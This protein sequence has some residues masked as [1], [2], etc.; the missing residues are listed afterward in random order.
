MGGAVTALVRRYTNRLRY[1]RLLLLTAVLFAVDLAV[2]DVLP[3]ADEILLG[4]ATVILA[5][6]RRRE[7]SPTP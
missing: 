2:P 7:P 1:P 6:L 3:F 4:L 5:R